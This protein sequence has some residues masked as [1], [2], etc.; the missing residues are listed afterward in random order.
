MDYIIVPCI[1]DGPG[2]KADAGIS[3]SR[4]HYGDF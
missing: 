3:N 4:D 2:G 1:V